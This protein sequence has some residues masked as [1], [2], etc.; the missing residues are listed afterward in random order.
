MLKKKNR[1]ILRFNRQET[2]PLV[3][4][5]LQPKSMVLKTH[6]WGHPPYTA[7]ETS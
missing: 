6:D 4:L 3:S 7:N 5:P 1:P 2:Q